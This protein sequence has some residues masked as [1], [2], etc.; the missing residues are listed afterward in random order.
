[1]FLRGVGNTLDFST[2]ARPQPSYGQIDYKTAG[3][4]DGLAING[5]PITGCGQRQ[6]RRAADQR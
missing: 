2:R 6:L 3:C 5:Q 1:M 4:L